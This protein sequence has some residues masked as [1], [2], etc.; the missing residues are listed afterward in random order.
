M[1]DSDRRLRTF[2]EFWPYYVGEHRKP[3]TR[4]WHFVGTHL[5]FGALV[6]GVFLSPW[7]IAAALVIGYGFSWVGHFF[8][9]HNGPATFKHP[10][11]SFRADLRMLRLTWT[12]KMGAEVARVTASP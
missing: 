1:S 6:L 3:S 8:F 12:G 2:E 9:E 4:A 11:W 5:G 7:W 10:L